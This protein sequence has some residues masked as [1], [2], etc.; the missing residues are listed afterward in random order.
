M[1]HVQFS[2]IFRFSTDF[3]PKFT[4]ISLLSGNYAEIS[5][6]IHIQP[7]FRPFSPR[8]RFSDRLKKS[9]AKCQTLNNVQFSFDIVAIFHLEYATRK[10]LFFFSNLYAYFPAVIIS[11]RN[12]YRF[13]HSTFFLFFQLSGTICTRFLR[14]SNDFYLFT[15]RV[16]HRRSDRK[17][18]RLS[19]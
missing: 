14:S 2:L 17:V 16:L 11:T 6:N 18:L 13:F 12:V 4:S 8:P 7:H 5:S 19:K 10:Q 9:Q 3:W 1:K 15:T